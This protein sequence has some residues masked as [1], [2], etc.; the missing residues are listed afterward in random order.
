MRPAPRRPGNSSTW[1]VMRAPAESISQNTGSSWARAC[2]VSRMIFSQ[3]AGDAV[4]SEE[5]LARPGLGQAVGV[6]QE[7]VAV[8]QLDLTAAVVGVAVD[9]EQR[10]GGPQR[11]HLAVV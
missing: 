8:L 10:S 6:Q 3:G 11:S 7:K 2:S 5:L 9:G 1:S 4:L